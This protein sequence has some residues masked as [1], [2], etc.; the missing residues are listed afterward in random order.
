MDVADYVF[1][2]HLN[3]G[4]ARRT[5]GYVQ[6]RALLGDVDLFTAKHGVATFRHTALPCQ[7]KQPAHGF[8][9]DPIL[10][11]IQVQT[12]AFRT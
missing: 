8:I 9:R 3:F 12:S 5:Q 11:I 2:V 1:A 10:G 4:S 6:N 7:F